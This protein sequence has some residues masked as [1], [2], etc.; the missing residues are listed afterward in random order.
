MGSINEAVACSIQQHHPQGR[1][2]LSLIAD[3]KLASSIA[4]ALYRFGQGVN[5]DTV[6]L[7][8]NLK[9]EVSTVPAPRKRGV[10]SG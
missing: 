7:H 2:R 3:I 1:P 9:S 4:K 10:K 8:K 5:D 6:R